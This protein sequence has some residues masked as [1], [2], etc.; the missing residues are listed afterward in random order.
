MEDGGT[1]DGNIKDGS[2]MN[3]GW[4]DGSIRARA[5]ARLEASRVLG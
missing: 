4:M 1:M 5:G 2:R 3:N